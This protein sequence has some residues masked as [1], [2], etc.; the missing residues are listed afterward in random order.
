MNLKKFVLDPTHKKFSII[1]FQKHRIAEFNTA[2]D[3][4]HTTKF[5]GVKAYLEK[6]IR[7]MAGTS[8]IAGQE[9]SLYLPFRHRK[10]MHG[11]YLYLCE[12][13][14]V[15][16]HEQASYSSFIRGYEA[17]RAE[18]ALKGVTLKLSGGNGMYI[19]VLLMQMDANTYR[20]D[21]SSGVMCV[22]MQTSY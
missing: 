10:F 7:E 12:Q 1:K 22:Q 5:S 9:K 4:T 11:E 3:F 21:H 14:G 13:K 20:Q 16:Y 2:C 15:P 6:T 18:L 19:Y 8:A 17:K